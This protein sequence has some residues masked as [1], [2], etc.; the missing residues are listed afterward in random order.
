MRAAQPWQQLHDAYSA[1]ASSKP[2]ALLLPTCHCPARYT[3]HG[4]AGY[5]A[6]AGV[7]VVGKAQAAARHICWQARR[8]IPA[9]LLQARGAAHALVIW[10]HGLQ[11]A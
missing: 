3:R 5:A 11:G 4:H 8:L 10:D 7:A 2:P 1:A 9:L 6:A